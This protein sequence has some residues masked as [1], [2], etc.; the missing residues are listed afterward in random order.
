MKRLGTGA[1]EGSE[2]IMGISI[3]S[4]GKKIFLS[5]DQLQ[6]QPALTN[7]LSL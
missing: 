6:L 7:E 2:H 1:L 3:I 4:Y 5:Y